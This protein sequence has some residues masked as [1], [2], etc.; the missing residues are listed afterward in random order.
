MNSKGEVAHRVGEYNADKKT[1]NARETGKDSEGSDASFDLVKQLGD[2]NQFSWAAKNVVQDGEPQP[3]ISITFT[4]STEP[5]KMPDDIKE[6]LGRAV[7][8]WVFKTRFGDK[9]LEADF[10]MQ[11]APG[12]ECL[13]WHH[14]GPGLIS[15]DTKIFTTG[16]LGWD[17][18]RQQIKEVAFNSLGESFTTFW[19]VR[20]DRWTGFRNGTILGK[21]F[22]GQIRVKWRP[23]DN[24]RWEAGNTN[25]VIEGEKQ[26]D[27][28]TVVSRK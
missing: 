3:G 21:K 20:K 22:S 15:S 13:V 23:G 17:H 25:F 8:Q 11:W 16:T 14:E 1:W 7:G 5:T 9:E 18:N 2:P 26:D 28:T 24:D 19:R 27:V 4:R 12:K 6:Y 10:S